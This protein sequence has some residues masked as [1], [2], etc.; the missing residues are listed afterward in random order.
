M[1]CTGSVLHRVTLVGPELI[2]V[3]VRCDALEW[4][5][6][7]AA[8]VI[9]V[10]INQDFEGIL[11]N[12]RLRGILSADARTADQA[13]K[14]SSDATICGGE[15]G[16]VLEEFSAPKIQALWSDFA[17]RDVARSGNLRLFV[18]RSLHNDSICNPTQKHFTQVGS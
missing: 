14:S 11:V 8:R 9:D 5:L 3:V 16:C 17:G 6:R 12:R 18:S 10:F 2:K 4:C 7:F 1:C 15:Q 13:P